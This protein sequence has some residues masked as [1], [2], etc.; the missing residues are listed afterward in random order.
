MDDPRRPHNPQLQNADRTVGHDD[1]LASAWAHELAPGEIIGGRY[2]ILSV[3]GRGGIGVVYEVEQVFLKQVLALKTLNSIQVTDIASVRLQ[4]EAQAASKLNHPNLVRAHDFGLTQNNEPFLTMELV[5]GES[6]AEYLHAHTRLTIEEALDI[7]IPACDAFAYA[8]ENGIIHRDIKP[9]NIL[10]V[11]DGDKL[12]PKIVDF[13]IAKFETA[14]ETQGLTRTGEIFGT[15]LYMSPEQCSGSVVDKRSDIY[16]FACVLYEA[17]TGGPPFVGKTA[18]E[19]IS[20]HLST[21]PLKLKEASLG[22]DFPPGWQEVISKALEKEPNNR[23]QNFSQFGEDLQL[24]KKGQR[25]RVN[26]PGQ[27][28]AKQI[29]LMPFALGL[30]LLAAT[31][32][33]AACWTMFSQTK[34][35]P[36]VNA[37]QTGSA[38]Q[39]APLAKP[40]KTL[41]N[42]TPKPAQ[43]A[44]DSIP[45][46]SP[47]AYAGPKKFATITGE[48]AKAKKHFDYGPIKF[49]GYLFDGVPRKDPYPAEGS[50]DLPATARLEVA[51]D[52]VSYVKQANMMRSYSVDDINGL[53]FR[54]SDRA[55]FVYQDEQESLDDA[56]I[57]ANHLSKCVM[58]DFHN[59]PVTMAGL[60]NLHL[61]KFKNLERLY[62]GKTNVDLDAFCRTYKNLLL[63]LSTIDLCETKNVT[64]VLN[65]LRGTNKIGSLALE[66]DAL[67]DADVTIVATMPR[68]WS[69]DLSNNPAITDASLPKLARLPQLSTLN[70]LG[71]S[72]GKKSLQSLKTMKQ[73][74]LLKIPRVAFTPEQKAEL[75]E[76]L[77]LCNFEF[78]GGK[79]TVHT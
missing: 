16:S 35:S 63:K 42:D 49:G 26:Q 20:Q 53:N 54:T 24:L 36:Q 46:K 22:H 27:M 40:A 70:L 17:L 64:T 34:P 12:I 43:E 56:L 1:S 61:T 73:L 76:A 10:L 48:G 11:R 45:S 55:T 47:F 59:C 72:V 39:P 78:G 21:K 57:Y 52:W 15:P 66:G 74:T 2:K 28:R 9:A 23:Y 31:A 38:A 68:L 18:I 77:P 8:H 3:L 30:S 19:T 5:R 13:G 62:L 51:M 60:E 75:Q 7:F 67:T 29:N 32:V 79:G 37:A 58:I 33:G 71:T 4:K 69:L 6:L 25:P 44:H 14:T 41:L 65:I 50:F